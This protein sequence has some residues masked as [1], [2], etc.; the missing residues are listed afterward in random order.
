MSMMCKP[1]VFMAK[2]APAGTSM[3]ATGC[4]FMTPASMVWE[5]SAALAAAGEDTAVR[6]TA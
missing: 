6:G 3:A 4:I 1:P 5:C 2:T